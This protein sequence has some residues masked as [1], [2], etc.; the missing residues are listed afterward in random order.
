MVNGFL[1]GLF[2]EMHCALIMAAGAKARVIIS[3]ALWKRIG[4]LYNVM[5]TIQEL[6]IIITS[7]KRVTI[8]KNSCYE[9]LSGTSS[10]IWCC[11]KGKMR[12][13][14]WSLLCILKKQTTVI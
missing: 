3:I 2:L 14:K 5:C 9:F 4:K 6:N 7:V 1:V 10:N 13:L 8:S 12:M 11:Q